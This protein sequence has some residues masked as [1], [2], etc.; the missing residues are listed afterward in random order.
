[1]K[2]NSQK[3]LKSAE[4]L[5]VICGGLLTA[6]PLA[7]VAQQQPQPQPNAKTNPCPK[8]F[9][10]EPHNSQVFVPQGCPPNTYTQRMNR[11]GSSSERTVIPVAPSTSQSKEGLGGETPDSNSS[12][13]YN[14]SQSSQSS[15][16]DSG[17]GNY[18]SSQQTQTS[19]IQTAPPQQQQAAVA[20]VI[21]TDGKISVRLVNQTNAPISYQALGDTAPRTLQGKSDVVLQGLRIP[22]TVTF[23]RQ[24]HGLLMVTPQG[25]SQQGMLQLTLRET[26]DQAI[27]KSALRIEKNGAVYLN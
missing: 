6:I 7:A 16:T 10:L 22:A 9:Y 24:D 27:D 26:T 4:L 15:M 1:M 12:Q 21:P 23:Y 25:S 18:S 14:S 20:T 19:V 17:S 11:Q 2:I 13:I 3:F 8:I 5:G